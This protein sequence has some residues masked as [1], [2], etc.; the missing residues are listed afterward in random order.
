MAATMPLVV[1]VDGSEPSLDT[2]D[3]AAREAALHM[4]PLRLAHAAAPGQDASGAITAASERARDVAA[5]LRLPSDVPRDDAVSALTGEGH[6]AFALVVGARGHGELTGLL[7]GSVGLAVAA[8][9]DCPVVVVR[10]SQ[11]HRTGRFGRI[12]VGVEDGAESDT[13]VE[14]A[15]REAHVRQC[16]LMA[17]H[18]WSAPLGALPEPPPGSWYALEAHRRPPAQVLDDVLRGPAKRYADATVPRRVVE[19]PARRALPE[20]AAKAD[21]LVVDAGERHGRPGLQ[22]GVINHVLLHHAPCP[23]MVVPRK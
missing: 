5:G 17:V 11:E 19:G 6:R 10:G 7:L 3:W 12:V 21:L 2:V 14:Y 20:A 1:G 15:F 22:L 23:V 16:E 8:R 9:A 18:A 13:A 4:M